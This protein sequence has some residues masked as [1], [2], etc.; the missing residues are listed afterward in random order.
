M[1]RLRVFAVTAALSAVWLAAEPAPRFDTASITPNRSSN[2]GYSGHVEARPG[3]PVRLTLQNV[4]L[5]F[6]VQQAYSVNEYQVAGPGWTK[7]MRYDISATLP[8]GVP[9]EQVWNALQTLLAERFQLSIR[10]EKKEMSIYA[11]KAAGDGPKLRAAASNRPPVPKFQP[12]DR[13][14]LRLG[15]N[16]NSSGSLRL[17]NVSLSEFCG[18]LSRSLNRPVIDATGIEGTFDVQFEYASGGIPAA[19]RKQL[20][21]RLEPRKDEVE[22]LIIG[23]AIRTPAAQ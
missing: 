6:C 8:T 23:Y 7:S 11:L 13:E 14:G 18:N 9:L 21:L 5:K 1:I 16:G 17:D 4:S 10:R 3:Q 22:M 15:S 19:L 2:R 12:G 20:G